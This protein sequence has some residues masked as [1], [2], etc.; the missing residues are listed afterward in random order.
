M[1]GTP[2][3]AAQNS[4]LVSV[5]EGSS[6]ADFVVQGGSSVNPED[7]EGEDKASVG[8]VLRVRPGGV[9]LPSRSKPDV[10]PGELRGGLQSTE[11]SDAGQ[12]EHNG[13]VLALPSGG[14]CFGWPAD[15]IGEGGEQVDLCLLCAFGIV[16][17][18]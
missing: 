5:A 1:P 6:A 17:A 16:S 14:A 13:D 8:S 11:E 12:V 2:F 9:A 3:F 4:T 10:E 7:P 18:P 15:G